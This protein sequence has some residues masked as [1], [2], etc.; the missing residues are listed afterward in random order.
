MPTYEEVNANWPVDPRDPDTVPVYDGVLGRSISPREKRALYQKNQ[1][2]AD[3]NRACN[4]GNGKA[5]MARYQREQ[6]IA[7]HEARIRQL[8]GE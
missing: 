3:Y 1:D 2:M 8:R 7:R 6:E 4:E 5:W